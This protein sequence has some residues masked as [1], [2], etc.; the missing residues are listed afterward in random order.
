MNEVISSQIPRCSSLAFGRSKR[1]PDLVNGEVPGRDAISVHGK[2]NAI[3]AAFPQ[4]R[5]LPAAAGIEHQP[6][7]SG[8]NKR[9]YILAVEHR[10]IR[11]VIGCIDGEIDP[12]G[13]GRTGKVQLPTDVSGRAMIELRRVYATAHR[14]RVKSGF[15]KLKRLK[16]RS[17]HREA[18]HVT[19]RRLNHWGEGWWWSGD[20]DVGGGRLDSPYTDRRERIGGGFARSHAGGAGQCN[21][22]DARFN[23]HIGGVCRSEEH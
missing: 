15:K 6:W 23:V 18:W 10:S 1:A 9:S 3:R 11:M 12:R 22:A 21:L 19:H 20:R 14:R 2:V 13:R 5:A 4:S 8:V 7:P 17:R 16:V